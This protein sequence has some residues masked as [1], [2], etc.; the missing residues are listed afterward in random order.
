MVAELEAMMEVISGGIGARETFRDT[1]GSSDTTLL[2]SK[3]TQDQV[4]AAEAA[5]EFLPHAHHSSWRRGG[6]A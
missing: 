2:Q 4:T 6:E 1:C 3:N 5:A